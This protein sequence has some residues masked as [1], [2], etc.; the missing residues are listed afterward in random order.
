MNEMRRNDDELSTNAGTKKLPLVAVVILNWNGKHFLKRFLPSVLASNY[1]NVQ[2]IVADNAST[3]D[4]ISFL[5]REHPAV[6]VVQNASNGGFA[7]GYNDALTQIKADY[8]VLLNSDVSV[9]PN[10]LEPIVQLME[11]NENIAA[12]QPKVLAFHQ[13]RLFEYAGAAGGYIDFLGY[14]FCRG[15]VL[16]ICEKDNGQYDKAQ[17]CFWATGAALVLKASL[18]WKAGG[19]D[20][21][22]FAHMEEIDLCWRLQR[23]GYQ[24][25]VEPKSIVYHVGGGTLQKASPYKTYLNFRNNLIMLHKNCQALKL[26]WLLPLRFSLDAAAAYRALLSGK[27]GHFWAIAKAHFGFFQWLLFKPNTHKHIKGNAELKGI[28]SNS[29]V[30]QYFVKKRR[31]FAEIIGN[32]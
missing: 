16:D 18:Y 13:P 28:S 27:P 10:W 9:A 21:Y 2:I 17:A 32:K 3:D 31:T 6:Q 8:Y 30:W 24:I 12:C 20:D 25:W 19:L 14:P 15:R 4:S 5:Q 1:K 7:K 29:L 26:C 23:M 22:F 11:D